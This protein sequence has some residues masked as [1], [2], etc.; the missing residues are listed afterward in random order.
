MSRPSVRGVELA[1]EEGRGRAAAGKTLVRREPLGL[2]GRKPL[3]D[4]Q[5]LGLLRGA[6]AHQRLALG[7]AIG[8][9]QFVM[10]L[11]GVGRLRRDEEID[12]HDLRA[13]VDEL[14]EGVL[15]VGAGLAPDHRAGGLGDRRAV[16]AHALA[17]A[18][19]LQLLEIGGEA[20][21]PL[22]VGDHRLRRRGPA[23]CD[24]RPTTAPS[25]SGCSRASARSGNARRR[26]GRRPGTP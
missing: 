11:V 25:A 15:A 6:A 17:V 22:V 23:R 12:G 1:V 26:R 20:A 13:L 5:R 8:E 9:E 10:R 2:G 24:S 21:E 16:E 19:H 14:E 7:E 3:R 18:L 4:H